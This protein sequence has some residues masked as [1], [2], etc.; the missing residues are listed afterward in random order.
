[1]YRGDTSGGQYLTVHEPNG[2][3]VKRYDVAD[4]ESTGGYLAALSV[5][6][7]FASL[8]SANC[9]TVYLV[10][11]ETDE[12]LRTDTD[13]TYRGG[14]TSTLIVGDS[15]YCMGHDYLYQLSLADLHVVKSWKDPELASSPYDSDHRR[16]LWNT[17]A[18][19]MTWRS[20]EGQNDAF[21]LVMSNTSDELTLT[22]FVAVPANPGQAEYDSEHDAVLFFDL[23]NESRLSVFSVKSKTVSAL[24]KEPLGASARSGVTW[25]ASYLYWMEDRLDDTTPH[26]YIVRYPRSVLE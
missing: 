6:G 4:P 2:D 23:Q 16:W 9:E 26:M 25:D 3:L 5:S 19:L 22:S 15:V 7:T 1:M 20:S 11:L 8:S 18:G 13:A 24:M 12:V 17:T 14:M 21:E 10:N